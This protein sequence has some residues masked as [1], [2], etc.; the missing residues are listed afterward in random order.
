MYCVKCGVELAENESKCPLCSTVVCHPDFFR[1]EGGTLYPPD[2]DSHEETINVSGVLFVVSIVFLI[3]ILLTLMFDWKFNS[4]F[5][6]SGYAVG[7][8]LLLYIMAVLPL[9]FKKP[10]PVIFSSVDFA[11]AALYLLYI[12]MFTQGGWF[13]SFAFPVTGG[14]A[15][16]SVAAITLVRYVRRG[17]LYIFGGVVIATGFFTVLIEFLLHVT[18]HSRAAL[19]WSVFPLAACFLAGMALIVIAICKPLRDSLHKKFF[20]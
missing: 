11:A 6:W 13:L 17:Y 4:G 9:W 5:T 10:N 20:V 16:I 3:P 19:V 7:A 8:I 18:F 14:A 2:P 15:L 1:S 12:D